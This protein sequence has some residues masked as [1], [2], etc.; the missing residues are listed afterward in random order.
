MEV[1]NLWGLARGAMEAIF[2]HYQPVFER[3]SSKSGLDLRNINQL[4]LAFAV[5]PETITADRLLQRNPYNSL[6]VYR[7]RL[8]E[9]RDKGYLAE[10]TPGEY[11]LTALGRDETDRLILESRAV[12]SERDPLP[13]W[14]SK[15]LAG[16]LDRLVVACQNTSLPMG[17]P[18]FRLSHALMPAQTP[19]LPYSE[20]ALTCLEAF[21]DDAHVAAWR[22]AGLSAIEVDVLT[23]LWRG[24]ADSFDS[25]VQRLAGRGH[26]P[27]DIAQTL[28]DLRS[29][30]LV[31]GAG[32]V[33]YITEAGKA[34]REQIEATTLQHTHTPWD[35][36][37]ENDRQKTGHLLAVLTDG[38]RMSGA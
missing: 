22:E 21:Y 13:P 23:N 32:E 38:L 28:A 15:A 36:L 26:D 31:D 19:P 20:Q 2:F 18:S 4:I 8:M 17:K 16:L 24:W 6:T 10:E 30:G 14:D 3:F 7:A 5:D 35:C 11:R 27:Q 9:V 1:D 33:S 29:R 34:L 12:M 25:L 37:D